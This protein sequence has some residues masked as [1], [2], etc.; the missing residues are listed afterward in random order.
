MSKLEDMELSLMITSSVLDNLGFSKKQI[1]LRAKHI[2]ERLKVKLSDTSNLTR[3]AV[4][5]SGEGVQLAQSDIDLMNT[6]QDTVCVDSGD[7]NHG[8]LIILG[9]DYSKTAQGYLR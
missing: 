3:V 9:T 8:E 5:S 6:F 4:G 7:G 2:E 1:L